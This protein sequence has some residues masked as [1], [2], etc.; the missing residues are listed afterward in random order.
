MNNRAKNGGT[1]MLL[2][3]AL[4]MVAATAAAAQSIANGRAIV[5]RNCAMCHAVGPTGD[6][7]RPPAPRFRELHWRYPIDDLAEGLAEGLRSGHPM[8]PEFR[9]SPS[10]VSDII[11]YLKSIQTQQKAHLEERG[12]VQRRPA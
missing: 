5:Q 12:R 1:I 4:S 11:A 8:M 2:A 3:T 7:P 10:E 6:S 9:F